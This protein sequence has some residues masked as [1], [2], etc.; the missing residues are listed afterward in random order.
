LPKNWRTPW[1]KA[2]AAAF[3]MGCIIFDPKARAKPAFRVPS[4][5]GKPTLSRSSDKRASGSASRT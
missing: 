2:Y 3:L 1:N 4:E 5:S